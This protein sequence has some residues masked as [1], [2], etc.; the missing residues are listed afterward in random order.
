MSL[1]RFSY[2]KDCSFY[3]ELS[4]LQTTYLVESQL[5][6]QEGNQKTCGDTHMGR[7]QSLLQQPVRNWGQQTREWAWEQVSLQC[8]TTHTPSLW[9]AEFAFKWQRNREQTG[10]VVQMLSH[11]QLFATPWTVSRQASVSFT[12]SRNLLKLMS[13][14]SVMSS[15]HLL[16]SSSS[17][18]QSSPASGSFPVNQLFPSGGQSTGA[19][20]SASVL[21]MN[22]QGWF[23]LG[24]TG[25]I[26]LF[27]KGL[28]RV[29]SSIAIWKHPLFGAQPL[30]G[31]TLTPVHDYWKNHSFDYTDL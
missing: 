8:S 19:S 1:S 30:Y 26:S 6:G 25:L 5:P 17:C 20:A 22:T 9:K 16:L 10:V 4:L 7:N 2:L 24:L 18:P 11:V 29:F 15:N 12:V 23:P 31:P 13:N 21:P 3:L 28:S 14:K 27:Y